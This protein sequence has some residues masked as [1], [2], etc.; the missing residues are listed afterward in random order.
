MS[1]AL[2]DRAAIV[3]VGYTELSKDS[4][5]STLTL[6]V[7]AI[8]AALADAGL[9]PSDI[10]GIATH[11]VGDSAPA[12]LVGESLGI[13][14]CRWHLDLHGGGSVSHSVIGQAALAVSAGIADTVVCW[15]AINSR[16]EN[17][18][19]VAPAQATPDQPEWQ[20]KAPYGFVTPLQQ[21]AAITRVYLDRFGYGRE[22]LGQVAVTQRQNAMSN[23]R[24]M[25]RTRLTIE[26]YLTARWIAEPIALFDCCLE[27]DAAVALVVTSAERARD[28]RQTPVTISGAAWGGGATLFRGDR[29]D[30]RFSASGPVATRLYQAADA[31]PSDIHVACLYDAFTT[32]VPLLLEDFKLCGT[33][34]AGSFILSGSTALDGRLPVNPHGGHLSEG[35]IHGLNHVAEAVQQLR[36][37]CGAR[38]VPRAEVALCTGPP[39]MVVGVTSGL[40]LRR[41]A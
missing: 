11:R 25:M 6:A 1:T 39:G 4:G 24:A 33:G 31:S 22:V 41:A 40:I 37:D 18:L 36:W 19:G 29:D 17:R 30:L 10:D 3:G 13:G 34:E 9:E 5:V 16:S 8:T 12:W 23:E 26:D 27:T 7:R 20:Y 15:R 21:F 28:L 2:R 35:Y 32:M 38:Q 14:D